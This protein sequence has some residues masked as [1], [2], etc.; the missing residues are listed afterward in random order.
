[1]MD[2]GFGRSLGVGCEHCHVP[3]HW[4]DEDKK[5]KQVA[6]DMMAMADTINRVLLPHIANIQ[7]QQPHVNCGTCHHGTA[8]PGAEMAGQRPGG[9]RA[10][11]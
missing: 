3:G 6:R 10:P 8:R 7:S 4:A 5:Q 1:M 9:D 11:R 2:M